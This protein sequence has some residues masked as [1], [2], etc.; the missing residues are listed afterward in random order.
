MADHYFSAEPSVVSQP[1]PVH[2]VLPDLSLTLV[3]DR[4]VFSAGRVDPGTLALLRESAAP[5]AS[6]AL[7]DL[8]CGYGPIACT[9]ARR[10]PGATVWAVDVNRRGLELT[11][12]NATA[13]G[14]A[15]VMCATPDAVPSEVSFAGI[16]SNPPVRVGKTALHEMLLGWL[17]RLQPGGGAWLVVNRHLGGDS[18]AA[19][20]AGR[21]WVV[22]RA[23]SKS[24]YRV[25][26]VGR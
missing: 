22:T 26:R 8:G 12:A 24:G 6:G 7:L 2:L 20:L 11:R 18:L 5:P 14:L 21:G 19:W 1:A 9:L 23:A 25:L 13:L 4:G 10:S 16:W 17:E 15:N 3:A